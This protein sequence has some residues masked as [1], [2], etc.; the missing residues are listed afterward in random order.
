MGKNS[1]LKTL[2]KRIG[3]VVLH[4]LLV[5]YT[6]RL[7]SKSHLQNEEITYLDE[8]VK[9]AR[10]YH[11]NEEDRQ[12]LK[13]QAAEFI[14]NKRNKKY[15]DVNFSLDEVEKLVEEEIISLKL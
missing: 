15:A 13:I 9:D 11:W 10:K 12:T 2:G 6:N 7:K 3:N 4:K 1:A 8:A 14:K 5:T